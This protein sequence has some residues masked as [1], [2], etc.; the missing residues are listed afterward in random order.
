M[1]QNFHIFIDGNSIANLFRPAF[2]LVV[3]SVI[4]HIF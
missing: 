2:R 1:M 4:M 3:D